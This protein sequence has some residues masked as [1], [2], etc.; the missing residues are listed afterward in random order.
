MSS[1]LAGFYSSCLLLVKIISGPI[2]RDL[3]ERKNDY[4]N[5]TVV[6]HY[7][8]NWSG[9]SLAWLHAGYSFSLTVVAWVSLGSYTFTY[10]QLYYR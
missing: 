2:K 9:I 3:M 1:P 4:R 6:L 8:R 7:G 10:T 5:V